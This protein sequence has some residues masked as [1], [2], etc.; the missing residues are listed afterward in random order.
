[1]CS[2]GT[3]LNSIG[4]TYDTILS[5]VRLVSEGTNIREKSPKIIVGGEHKNDQLIKM[6]LVLLCHWLVLKVKKVSL[7]ARVQEPNWF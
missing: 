7:V 6:D 1:M 3:A 5:I 2:K 4:K